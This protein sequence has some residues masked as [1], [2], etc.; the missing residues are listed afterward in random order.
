MIKAVIEVIQSIVSS[1]IR[2]YNV[3]ENLGFSS[4]KLTKN[5]AREVLALNLEERLIKDSTAF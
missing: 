2:L 5:K 3:A 4:V 1:S